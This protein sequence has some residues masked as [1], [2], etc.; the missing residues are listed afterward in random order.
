MEKIQS[1]W[2]PLMVGIKLNISSV[3][4]HLKHSAQPK[5]KVYFLKNALENIN[6]EVK[7]VILIMQTNLL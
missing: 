5:L 7:R 3:I 1:L 6:E 2:E 4:C